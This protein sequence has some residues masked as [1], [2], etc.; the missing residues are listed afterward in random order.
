M[1]QT[2]P[3]TIPRKKR[4]SRDLANFIQLRPAFPSDDLSVAELLLHTFISTYAQKLPTITTSDER[5]KELRDVGSRRK[6]GY[7]CIAELGYRTIGTF[8]L[9]H[10]ES[11]LSEA[12]RPN[13]ATLRCLA[14]DPE[15][16]GL[17]LS[18]LLLDE[19][20]RVAGAWNAGAVFLHV[21]NGADRVATL[22]QRHGYVR[23]PLG[24]KISHGSSLE[25]YCKNLSTHDRTTN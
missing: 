24:D 15:F 5:K 6:Q 8:S 20:D 12:W 14:I 3:L 9:I 25:G 17:A 21:Q 7:V 4:E 2:L 10:P 19:A 18:E 1:D 23:D 22:Y 11:P 16:H 13:G